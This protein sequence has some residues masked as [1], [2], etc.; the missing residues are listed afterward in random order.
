M[1]SGS[2]TEILAAIRSESGLTALSPDPALEAAALQQAKLMASSGRMVH[3]TAR[4]YDF[5]ARMHENGITTASAENIAHGGMD[6][7]KLFRMWEDSPPHRRN[8][9]DPRFARFGLASAEDASGK[10]FWAL[11]MGR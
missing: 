5:T 10:R 3:T 8:M 4:G 7:P 1:R 9:L 2:A 6:V 11:V